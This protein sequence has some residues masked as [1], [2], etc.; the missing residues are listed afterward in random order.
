MEIYPLF[1]NV[2]DPLIFSHFAARALADVVDGKPAKKGEVYLQTV[3]EKCNMQ[4][5]KLVFRMRKSRSEKMKRENWS[6]APIRSDL[7]ETGTLRLCEWCR[8]RSHAL[9]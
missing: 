9:L 3:V 6:L 2:L 1:S 4:D 8:S 5:W 7:R